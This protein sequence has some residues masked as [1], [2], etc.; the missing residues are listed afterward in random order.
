MSQQSN[1]APAFVHP[2]GPE[3][4]TKIEIKDPPEENKSDESDDDFPQSLE[5]ALLGE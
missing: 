4:E 1:A 2:Y 5:E 3:D